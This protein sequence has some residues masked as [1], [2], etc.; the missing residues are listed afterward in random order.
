MKAKHFKKLRKQLK[1]YD[2]DTTY[3]LF[4]DFKGDSWHTVLAKNPKQ[5]CYRLQKRGIGRNLTVGSISKEM[6]AR[7]R[8]KLTESSNHWRNISYFG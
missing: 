1:W 4:G 8:V 5:A 3:G 6:W 7:F 2:V